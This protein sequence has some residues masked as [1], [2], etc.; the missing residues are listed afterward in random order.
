MAIEILN[1]YLLVYNTEVCIQIYNWVKYIPILQ[2]LKFLPTLWSTSPT[3]V[4]LPRV[5]LVP[6]QSSETKGSL[7]L[8]PNNWELQALALEHRLSPTGG[9]GGCIIGSHQQG[10]VLAGLGSVVLILVFQ[11]E[12]LDAASL[13]VARHCRLE[14]QCHAGASA[15]GPRS[16]GVGTNVSHWELWSEGLGSRPLDTAS[17]EQVK[18]D[19]A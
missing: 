19:E 5:S 8:C 11:P 7:I 10:E 17:C 18:L 15:R 12:A 16:W 3:R 2:I 4:L 6:R 14:L 1:I 13:H 9:G